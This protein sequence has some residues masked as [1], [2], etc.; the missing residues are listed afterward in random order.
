MSQS[1]KER[2]SVSQDESQEVSKVPV[3]ILTGFFLLFFLFKLREVSVEGIVSA[4]GTAA[5]MSLPAGLLIWRYHK[6]GSSGY[7]WAAFI[8]MAAIVA[9]KVLKLT[10]G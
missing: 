6:T 4:S 7:Y 5:G 1:T 2:E 9:G 8:F 3:S 10:G